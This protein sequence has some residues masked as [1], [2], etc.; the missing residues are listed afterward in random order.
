MFPNNR[1]SFTNT[2]GLHRKYKA[3]VGQDIETLTEIQSKK[4][5]FQ[6]NYT[7]IEVPKTPALI[8]TLIRFVSVLTG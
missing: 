6:L 3:P 1:A 2:G 8:L 4:I 5:I 7:R